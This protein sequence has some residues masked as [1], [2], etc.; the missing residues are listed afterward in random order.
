[1]FYWLQD[2]EYK[3]SLLKLK[4]KTLSPFIE[5]ESI[6]LVS[7]QSHTSKYQIKLGTQLEPLSKQFP[8]RPQTSSTKSYDDLSTCNTKSIPKMKLNVK[9]PTEFDKVLSKY[10][11]WIYTHKRLPSLISD[12]NEERQLGIWSDHMRLNRSSLTTYQSSILNSTDVWYWES[13]EVQ[14]MDRY[15]PILLWV[16]DNKKMPTRNKATDIESS[17]SDW[18]LYQRQKYKKQSKALTEFLIG[19]LKIIP[20]WFWS[21]KNFQSHDESFDEVIQWVVE[22]G[23]LPH[24]N[25][26]DPIELKLARWC[27]NQR[28]CKKKGSLSDDKIKQLETIPY[29]YWV[30]SDYDCR[31]FVIK[32]DEL[33]VWIEN[34]QKTPSSTSLDPI[35]MKM[36]RFCGSLRH[37]KKIGT[38]AQDKIDLL[39]NIK[40]WW[41]TDDTYHR[42][43][44]ID[45]VIE[46]VKK[47]VIDNKYLPRQNAI[48]QNEMYLG[49]WCVRQRRDYR[50][51]ELSNDVIKQIETIPNWY[52]EYTGADIYSAVAIKWLDSISKAINRPLRTILSPDNEFK[53][54]GTLYCADGYDALTNTIYEFLGDFWHG[55]PKKFDSNSL[56]PISKIRDGDGSLRRATYGEVYQKTIERKVKIIALGY[57]YV[58]IWETDWL[59]SQRQVV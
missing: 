34:H 40:G 38:L 25:Q 52:W 22:H 39:E 47:W 17:H 53:I 2:Y 43:Q 6:D 56:H 35:V 54:P 15:V 55:N 50:K 41:W 23:D 46:Q 26:N 27:E 3:M 4:F 21:Y 18:C 28:R 1:M 37:Q 58:E 19:K 45:V 20:G 59:L 30:E 7:N 10:K 9:P 12:D 11:T 5:S 29:W 33:R 32:Y 13:S 14:F 57:N 8:I 44:L 24:K 16:L 51:K 36:G 42:V 49:Q 48:D 31:S